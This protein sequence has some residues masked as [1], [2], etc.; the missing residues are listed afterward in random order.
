MRKSSIVSIQWSLFGSSSAA[1]I[2]RLLGMF[3]KCLNRSASVRC[4][5]AKL[6]VQCTAALTCKYAGQKQRFVPASSWTTKPRAK[7]S[8]HTKNLEVD[9]EP[10][11]TALTEST[12]KPSAAD[13][14]L[15]VSLLYGS[16]PAVPPLVTAINNIGSF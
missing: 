5:S 13:K 14:A 7:T 3:A 9:A 15:P 11:Y 16:I 2:H 1:R 10:V 4:F 12:V 6:V 8:N